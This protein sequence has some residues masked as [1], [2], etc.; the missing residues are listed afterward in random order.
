M[1]ERFDREIMERFDRDSFNFMR[2][3]PARKNVIRIAVAIVVLILLFF[4]SPFGTIAAGERGV[5]LRFTA[6]TGK[7]FGEGLYFRIPLIESVQ[8]MDVKVQKY[9]MESAAASK[10]LQTVHSVVALNFHIDPDRVANIYQEVGLQFRDRLIDPAM[11][12]AIKASTAKFTAEEL[13]TKREMVRDEI[14]AQLTSRLK[15]RNILVDEFNIVNFEF[16]KNF[17]DAIE[18]KVTAEQQALAAKNKLEQIKFEADQKIAE[19]RGKAEAMTIE[20]NAL[21]SNP[22]ILELRALEK[23]NGTLPQV[24]GGAIPF[25]N[26]PK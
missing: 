8:M 12:E 26:L 5:H 19:A 21:R 18:A 25:I 13:I 24:T 11:Q 14:K 4:L 3:G 22:Q 10:D 15:S 6:V 7:L 23:W 17:N 1:A 9:E 2:Q 20:S 16:S